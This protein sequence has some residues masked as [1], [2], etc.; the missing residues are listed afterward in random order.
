MTGEAMS[1]D[2]HQNIFAVFDVSA[3]KRDVRLLIENAL[4][5][6]HAEIAVWRGQRRFAVL[7][8]EAFGPEP[9]SNEFGDRYDLYAVK[10]CEL[11]PIRNTP[12]RSIFLH[13][14]AD[15]AGGCQTCRSRKIDRRFRLARSY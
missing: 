7:L 1:L 5:D 2:A 13:D 14:F 12:H 8:D 4:K 3:N 15:P 10:L 11:D 6:K 9:V